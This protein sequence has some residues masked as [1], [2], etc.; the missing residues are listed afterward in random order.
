MKNNYF[1]AV[2]VAGCDERAGRNWEEGAK[3]EVG[4]EPSETL[5]LPAHTVYLLVQVIRIPRSLSM[6]AQASCLMTAQKLKKK[7]SHCSVSPLWE[8]IPLGS[9]LLSPADC[10]ARVVSIC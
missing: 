1:A 2:A 5:F 7:K 6:S 10:T 9:W 3:E 4:A 8:Q